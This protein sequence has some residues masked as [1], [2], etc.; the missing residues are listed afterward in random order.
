M[1]SAHCSKVGSEPRSTGSDPPVPGWSKKMSRPSV[2][3]ASI[4]PWRDGSSGK[5][6][7]H[8][9]QFGTNTMSQAPGGDAR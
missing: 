4:Q 6:S 2:V 3:I 5:T 9:N 1:L 8:V 7:Q